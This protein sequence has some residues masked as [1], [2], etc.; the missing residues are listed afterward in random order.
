[1]ELLLAFESAG[2][3]EKLADLMAKDSS[4]VSRNLQRLATE[5]PVLMKIRGRWCISP[6]GRQLNILTRKYLDELQHFAKVGSKS[7]SKLPIVPPIPENSL[8]I[9][10]NAQ[11]ALHDPAK[12][13]RSNATAEE[14]IL[15]IL[16]FWR[17]RK[18]HVVH[19]KHVS[20]SPNSFFYFKSPGVD[21]ISKIEPVAGENIFE[22]T[23]ASAFVGTQLEKFISDAEV[24]A[25]VLVG[26]TGG[27]C[28]D[29][30]ARQ[31]SDLGFHTFV[32]G[33]ATATFD[34]V[35]PKGKLIKA[36]KVHKNTLAHLNAMFAKV[37][38]TSE[39]LA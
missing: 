18:R 17:K 23:K 8:L 38:E 19:I 39:A 28:I 37:L 3:L 29:A 34:I 1:M 13:R 20:Q 12:G 16:S 15:K 21:F 10:I 31:S 9:V 4:V 22:K 11:K 7:K 30:T 26:F 2:N 5:L 33:D 14:N 32:V 35:G 24:D 6:L 27:E 25:V 36:D